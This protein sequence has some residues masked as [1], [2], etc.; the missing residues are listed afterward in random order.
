MEFRILG[1]FEVVGPEGR[2]ELRGAKRRG[3]LAL[4]LVHA[5]QRLSVDHIVDALWEGSS[6][7]G[8][9]GTVQTYVSQLRRVLSDPDA[10]LLTRH[11]GYALEV[12]SDCLDSTRFVHLVRDAD[13]VAD[14]TLRVGRLELALGLWRGPPLEEFADTAWAAPERA[15]LDMLHLHALHGRIEACL[16]LGRHHELV[17]EL[18]TMVEE[19]RLDER[20][21]GQLMVAYYR[22]GR[23][24]DALRAYQRARSLLAD[25]LGIDP[26][27]E[28][29]D[30]ERKVLDHDAELM[31]AP[32][33]PPLA[34]T[35]ESLPQGVVTFLL[36]DIEGSTSLWDEDSD[37]MS[38]AIKRY[39]ELIAHSVQAHSGR[40]VKSRG[41]GNS[42]LSV[43][44]RASDAADAAVALQRGLRA[45]EW[46]GDLQIATRV[47]LHTGEAYERDDDYYGGPLNRAA[48]IRGLAAG[49]QILCSRPTR[50]LVADRLP[51]EVHLVELGAHAL[52]GL[53]RPETIYAIVHPELADVAPLTLPTAIGEPMIVPLPVRFTAT[54][55]PFVGREDEGALLDGALKAV[56]A[57]G[58]RRTVVVAGE[59]GVG[60]TTLTVHFAR[61]AH[62][63]GA[64]VLAG[65]CDEDLGIPYQPW[66]EALAHVVRHAPDWLLHAH[67]SARGG[68]LTR[69]VPVLA[70]RV[71]TPPPASSDPG[72]ERY[73]LFGAVVDFLERASQN[74][75]VVLV[76]DD[77]HWADRPTLQLLRHVIGAEAQLRLLVVM[78][79]RDT[80]VPDDH[81]IAETLAALHREPGVERTSLGGLD[82]DALGALLETA[83]GHALDADGLALRDTLAAET[84][85]NPFFVTEVLRHLVETGAVGQND[86]GRWIARTSRAPL[87]L[88]ASVREVITYRV[89]HLGEHARH[90]LTLAAVIGRE[91]DLD[92]LAQVSELDETTIL[93]A[94]DA[95]AGAAIVRLSADDAERYAF[96]HALIEHTLL[97]GLS[98]PRRRRAHARVADALEVLCGDDPGDRITEL[99]HHY[100]EGGHDPDKAIHNAARA[101]AYA[102]GHLAPD[103]A[104]H[105]YRQALELLE[106]TGEPDDPRRGGL[107]LGLGDAQRQT[108]DAV[109][110]E[111]LLDAAA[112]A[113]RLDDTDLLVRAVIANS[114][115]MMSSGGRADTERIAALEAARSATEGQRTRERALVLAT[116]AAELGVTDRAR[117][118]LLADEAIALAHRLGDDPTL[119]T[120]TTRMEAAVRAPDN[121]AQRCALADEAIAAAER[122]GDSVLRWYAA[123]MNYTPALESGDIEA[124]HRRLDVVQLLAHEIG[125]PHMRYIAAFAQSLRE[126]LGGSLNDAEQTAA[127]ALE[128]GANCGQ[129]DAFAMYGGQITAIRRYQGRITELMELIEQTAADNPG[130]PAF[131]AALADCYCES[132]RVADAH[133][134]LE[135]DT[136]D[137]FRAFPFDSLWTSVMTIYSRVAAFAG[138]Q[139]VASRLIELLDPWRDQVATTG[140]IVFGSLAHPL[141][142]VLAITDRL[143]EAEDA[144]GQAAT[145]NQRI[146]APILLAETHLELA[147]LLSRRDHDSDRTRARELAHAAHTVATELGASSIARQAA[148][149]SD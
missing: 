126:A 63:D 45:E 16:E 64:I 61:A 138:D 34:S 132:G 149:L 112:V 41:E 105:W 55:A 104:L 137:D 71:H 69:L 142:L 107:L 85:G 48:R 1:P 31:L 3:L 102:L 84:D 43:F 101:G 39:E 40:M 117:M 127:L 52:K 27:A 106:R 65:H 113:R 124:F 47:A 134:L 67:V 57:D 145:V 108:G 4:L 120:V 118:R 9:Y 54:D 13:S 68:E 10:R 129:P 75:P 7:P 6:S 95:A 36:T 122:T 135:A 81:P 116:L 11:G 86:D 111:T 18:E 30:L 110:R 147:R 136:A 143:D 28:L 49:G 115:G 32:P 119:V 44:A 133:A 70:R 42:T 8:A 89:S 5:G 146:G 125:Q 76:L 123:T 19:H 103:D 96:V 12:A 15:R 87:S 58:R 130:I 128:I 60:K 148:Q 91:F 29:Q 37:G 73:L 59:P 121:L 97:D 38:Q 79:H 83:A 140:A 50:D 2:V 92:V 20:L 17:G 90:I 14:P 25:E 74:A 98:P 99:A 100:L 21:W 77:L 22:S 80:D 141:G 109:H 72:A 56:S 144:F 33:A 35:D 88:P 139:R 93:D 66:T 82:V 51:D 94:I 46:P 78:V 23:Q 26:G 62:E 24:A 53:K 114:R 131:R